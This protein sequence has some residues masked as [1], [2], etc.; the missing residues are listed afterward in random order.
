[1]FRWLVS[2]CVAILAVAP[3]AFGQYSTYPGYGQP[4]LWHV[5]GDSP[6]PAE[7]GLSSP[8]T[9]GP[10]PIVPATAPAPAPAAQAAAEPLKSLPQTMAPKGPE[11]PVSACAGKGANKAAHSAAVTTVRIFTVRLKSRLP[12]RASLKFIC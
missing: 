7:A 2:A 5:P 4:S 11:S 8:G 6:R 12:A 1:M 9:F 3:A 10:S